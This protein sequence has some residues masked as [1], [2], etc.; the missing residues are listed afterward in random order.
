MAQMAEPF[1]LRGLMQTKK[2]RYQWYS[3][4]FSGNAE[5]LKKKMCAVGKQARLPFR[6]S[7]TRATGL[8]DLNHIWIP[9]IYADQWKMC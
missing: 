3:I 7:G 9:L 2:R 4:D 5:I 6:H 8:L 1:K